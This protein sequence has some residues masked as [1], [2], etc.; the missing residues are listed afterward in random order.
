MKKGFTLIELLAVLAVIGVIVMISVPII[1]GVI[2]T[3]KNKSCEKQIEMI[4]NAARTYMSKHSTSL[5]DNEKT[6]EIEI[7]TLKEEGLLEG[8]IKNPKNN[9]NMTGSVTV[10]NNN[11]KY[12]YE[13]SDE[14]ACK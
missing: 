9:K 6:Y 7:E 12:K 4:K 8:E 13:Y 10:T 2:N 5:P 1:S 3:S 14:N 11:E